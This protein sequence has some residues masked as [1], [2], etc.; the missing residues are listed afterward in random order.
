M[1]APFE[2]LRFTLPDT[3]G[4]RLDRAL[5]QAAPDGRGLSR[6]R[7]QSLIADGA[8]RVPGGEVNCIDP[9]MRVAGGE[10]IEVRLPPPAP[11]GAAPEA[12]PIDVV[13]EDAHL[14]VLDKPAG[15]VVHPAPGAAR[16][17]ARQRAPAPLRRQ[18]VG[19]GRR[20]ASRHR[21][22]DR[23]G[24]VGSPRRGEVGRGPSGAGRAVRGA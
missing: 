21:A 4:E 22:P 20:A 3:P 5:A 11:T 15:L 19:R 7:L 17:H 6:T 16:R 8:V 12:I 18:P 24:H 14:I 23:Q 9:S 2:I 10:A 13:F 1:S